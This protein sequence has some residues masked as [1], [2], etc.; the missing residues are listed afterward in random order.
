MKHV[1]LPLLVLAVWSSGQ[2]GRADPIEFA[3]TTFDVPG[4]ISTELHG[5]NDV[6]QIVGSYRT[7]TD[8]I[9][10]GFL[11]DGMFTTIDVPP[12]VPGLPAVD[13]VLSGINNNGQ[14]VGTYFEANFSN[15]HAFE[16]DNRGFTVLDLPNHGYG[17]ANNI[18]DSGQIVGYFYDG[19]ARGFLGDTHGAMTAI[20]IPGLGMTQARAINNLGQIVLVGDTYDGFLYAN[21]GFSAIHFP[22]ARNTYLDGINDAGQIVGLSSGLFD[23]VNGF[24]PIVVPGTLSAIPSDINNFGQIVGTFRDSAGR[25]HGFVASPVPE[26]ASLP[27]VAAALGGCIWIRRKRVRSLVGERAAAERSQCY[28]G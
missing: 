12:L 22:G 14:I 3:F 26:P 7:S 4:A 19:S 9:L 8:S 28:I 17:G 27:L 15:P 6:G 21:G 20:T 25:E 24:S 16:L 10:H 18:N 11:Y 1:T 5:I 2:I 13:T 23:P